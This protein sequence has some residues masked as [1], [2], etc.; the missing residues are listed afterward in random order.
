MRVLKSWLV[1]AFL[2]GPVAA[3][4]PAQV[5]TAGCTYMRCALRIE[6]SFWGRHLV[7]GTQGERVG[8]ISLFG[9]VP[10]LRERA[11]SSG[12]YA[13]RHADNVRWTAVLGVIGGVA[14]ATAVNLANAERP[15]D[16]DQR[17]W[18]VLG[19]GTAA[20]WGSVP[21]SLRAQRSLSRAVWWYNSTLP[22][23]P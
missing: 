23:S 21:F 5:D 22:N 3:P 17:A 10:F 4:L 2:L 9:S 13:R 7:R 8:G 1:A 12:I 19:I 18:V 6:Q 14:L 11:D 20:L 16:F 15:E